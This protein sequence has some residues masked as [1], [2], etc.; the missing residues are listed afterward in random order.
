MSLYNNKLHIGDCKII[1]NQDTLYTTI[2]I[3]DKSNKIV[4]EL[5]YNE[6][7]RLINS[8]A[9]AHYKYRKNGGK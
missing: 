8:I 5:N 3:K 1:I 4:L 7:E 6:G 2:E 9:D